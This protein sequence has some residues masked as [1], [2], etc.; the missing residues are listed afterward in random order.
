MTARASA[1]VAV[2]VVAALAGGFAAYRALTR[3]PAEDAARLFVERWDSGDDAAAARATDDATAAAAA[4]RANPVS[5]TH[6]TLP[7]TPYV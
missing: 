7:T 2:L 6:L 1:L 4:L 5:Y 3:E